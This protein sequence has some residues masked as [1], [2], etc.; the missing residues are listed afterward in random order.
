M[1]GRGRE[2]RKEEGRGGGVVGCEFSAFLS[3]ILRKKGVSIQTII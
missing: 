1:E 3:A 2:S